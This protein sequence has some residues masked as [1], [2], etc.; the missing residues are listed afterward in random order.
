MGSSLRDIRQ[1]P[2]DVQD[3]F[4]R[5]FLDAQYGDH[6][7]GARPFGEGMSREILK[8]SDDHVGE[9]Y[10]AAYTVFPEA[11]YVLH[12]FQKKSRRGAATPKADKRRIELRLKLALAHYS[13][14][15][16]RLR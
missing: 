2:A 1:L 7:V 10:R 5:A 16:L 12:V 8:L 11:V 13:R 3:V 15:Y 9:T 6:P 14:N 4:G